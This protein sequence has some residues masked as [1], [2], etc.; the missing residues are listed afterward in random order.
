V[1]GEDMIKSH[2]TRIYPN[3]EQKQLLNELF[4]YSRYCYNLGLET[5]NEMYDNGEKT[6]HYKVRDKTKTKRDKWCKKYSLNIFET[7]IEDLNDAFNMFFKG[8]NKY[9]KFK[10]KRNFKNSFRIHKKTK[11]T[12]KINKENKSIRV[13]KTGRNNWIKLAELPR[14]NG[15]IK[16][17]TISKKSN[18]YFISFTIE[19]ESNKKHNKTN[20]SAGVDLGLKDFATVVGRDNDNKNNYTY[21]KY[22]Y[23]KKLITIKYH[24]KELQKIL[25][26]KVKGSNNYKRVRTKLQNLYLKVKNI[27]D[28]FLHKL[29]KMLVDN[30][31][32]ITIEDLNVSGMIKNKNLS[33]S[34]YESLFYKFKK[35]LQYKSEWNKRNL[36]IADRW[37]PSTQTCPSCGNVKK[38]KDKLNLSQRIYE[39]DCGHVADRDIN[40]GIN[41][42]EYGLNHI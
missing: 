29:T 3:Q 2:K 39:C 21:K 34:I 9:P 19:V 7:A 17:Y 40:A 37:F 11:Y 30:Y 13:P 4:G 8:I 32:T 1:G 22:N 28:D 5:W 15:K 42:L 38:G 23:P 6:S 12:I 25:S 41:L 35:F 16:S 36:M 31:D 24:I 20:K 18:K 14:F 33:S 10:S 27:K 26:R